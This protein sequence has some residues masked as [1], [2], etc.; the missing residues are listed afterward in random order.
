MMS[1][2]AFL[3][4]LVLTLPYK[5]EAEINTQWK[6]KSLSG[7]V[8]WLMPVWCDVHDADGEGRKQNEKKK[9]STKCHQKKKKQSATRRKEQQ[10]TTLYSSKFWKFSFLLNT[11]SLFF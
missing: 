4:V 5:K 9:M 6:D 10:S 3:T 11:V 1:R 7:R 8:P 2:A